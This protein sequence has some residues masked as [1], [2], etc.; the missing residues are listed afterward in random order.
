MS[1]GESV[2]LAALKC[3]MS[4]EVSAVAPPRLIPANT[5]QFIPTAVDT[6]E[7]LTLRIYEILPRPWRKMTVCVYG[8][9]GA[10]IAVLSG[11]MVSVRVLC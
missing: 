6:T 9:V 7:H 10:V 1:H 3:K 2:T 5:I 8:A 11:S 4:S